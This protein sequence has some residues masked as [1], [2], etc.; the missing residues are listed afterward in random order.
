M[1]YGEYEGNIRQGN[2][3]DHITLGTLSANRAAFYRII[4]IIHANGASHHE[5]MIL[6]TTR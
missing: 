4:D 2:G 3:P 5:E 1:K 6:S